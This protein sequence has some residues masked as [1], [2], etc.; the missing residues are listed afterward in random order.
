MNVQQFLSGLQVE[1]DVLHHSPSFSAQEMAQA[2]HT[3]GK[4]VAKTVLLHC[5]D[6]DEYMVAVLPASSYV[7]FQKV[8]HATGH[9]GVELASEVEIGEMCPDCEL[10]AL[11]PFGSQYH[12]RTIVDEDLGEDEEIVF[13]GNS[14]EESVRMRF[15]DFMRIEQPLQ[16][17]FAY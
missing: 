9:R 15:D 10:G 3:S 2:T 11:P 7:N 4:D 5:E 14:H 13:E 6:D 1:F 17:S 12:M 8:E 16:A